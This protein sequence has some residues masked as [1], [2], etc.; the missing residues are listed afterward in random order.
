MKKFLIIYIF[1]ILFMAFGIACSKK[2]A[3]YQNCSP[4]EYFDTKIQK[5]EIVDN[6]GHDYYL[7]E[8]GTRGGRN[9]SFT[10]EHRNDCKACL[11]IF[12]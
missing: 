11:D 9:Y 7:Y 12:D 6:E 3:Y 1:A 10:L 5:S 4:Q 2:P 8:V